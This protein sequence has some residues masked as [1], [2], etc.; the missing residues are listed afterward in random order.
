[1]VGLDQGP[2]VHS[3]TYIQGGVMKVATVRQLQISVVE[4]ELDWMLANTRD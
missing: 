1:M 4:L 2:K 3:Y